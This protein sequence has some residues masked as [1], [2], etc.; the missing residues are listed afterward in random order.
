MA[1]I[2]II[3]A[4]KSPISRLNPDCSAINHL[5]FFSFHVFKALLLSLYFQTAAVP[6]MTLPEC[7][8]EQIHK[9]CPHLTADRLCGCIL[10]LHFLQCILNQ[11]LLYRNRSCNLLISDGNCVHPLV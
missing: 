3:T 5:F 10:P 8:F 1:P 9:L 11:A 2:P 6:E 7:C 4:M